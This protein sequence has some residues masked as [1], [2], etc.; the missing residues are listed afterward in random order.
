DLFG[1]MLENRFAAPV[2]GKR[3]E[4]VRKQPDK[5]LAM[6]R[7]VNDNEHQPAD[8]VGVTPPRWWPP[9]DAGWDP[10]N[11]QQPK[12][13]VHK[14]EGADLDWLVYR[15]IGRESRVPELINDFMGYNTAVSPQHGPP[16]G[17]WVGDL[18]VECE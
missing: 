9:A 15:H 12:K 5:V 10:D 8:L 16:K 3:F 13:F 4:I 14:A 2:E 11:R 1:K 18:Q 6:R 7:L 17:N